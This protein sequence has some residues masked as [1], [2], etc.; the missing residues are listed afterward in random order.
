VTPLL[1]RIECLP[2]ALADTIFG[3]GVTVNPAL[4]VG[5]NVDSASLPITRMPLLAHITGMS[6]FLVWQYNYLP[7]H[8]PLRARDLA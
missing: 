2:A 1:A 3:H 7:G 5:G 6:R 4:A 8:V